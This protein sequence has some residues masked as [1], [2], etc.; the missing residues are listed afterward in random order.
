MLAAWFRMK[1]PHAAHAALATSA[2][3]LYFKGGISPYAYAQFATEVYAKANASC[4]VNIRK[5]FFA[6][7]AT[8]T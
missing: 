1:Y 6:L 5:G 3:I 2:P 7:N 8:K 4:P